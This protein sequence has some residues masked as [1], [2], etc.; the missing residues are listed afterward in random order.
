MTSTKRRYMSHSPVWTV[1]H[2]ERRRRS[3]IGRSGRKPFQAGC[4]G[5]LEVAEGGAAGRAGDKILEESDSGCWGWACSLHRSGKG[6]WGS[7]GGGVR[8]RWVG[9]DQAGGRIQAEGLAAEDLAEVGDRA[10][11]PEVRS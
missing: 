5:C 8:C 9:L 1:W 11:V 10:E 4:R 2:R 3:G 7:V 6:C